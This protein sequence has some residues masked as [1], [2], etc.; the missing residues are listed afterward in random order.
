MIYQDHQGDHQNG[1]RCTGNY[2]EIQQKLLMKNLIF[3][4]NYADVFKLVFFK[5]HGTFLP[6]AI[7]FFKRSTLKAYFGLEKEK[8]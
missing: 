3:Q 5:V 8:L 2:C 6:V 4:Q 1:Y 7:G